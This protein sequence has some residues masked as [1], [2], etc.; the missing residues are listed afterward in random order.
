[1]ANEELGKHYEAIGEL[2]LALEAYTRMQPDLSTNK[3]YLECSRLRSKIYTQQRDW[4]AVGSTMKS[5]K[6]LLDEE[7]EDDRGYQAYYE[8]SMGLS[9][10]G[11][12]QYEEAVEHFLKVNP[13][14]S[15]DKY[16]DLVSPNDIATYG[17]LLALATKGRED[18]RDLLE[19]STYRSFSVT[20]PHLRK[21]I[22]HFVNA[23][24][25]ACL[26]VLESYRPD[27]LLD[28]YLQRHV[29]KLYTKIRQ[30]CIVQYLKPFSR[31]T[32]ESMEVFAA[33]GKCIEEDLV[34]M[35][36]AGTLEARIDKIDKV[37]TTTS[38]SPR[39]KIQK[40]SIN[41]L[42]SY[43][44]DALDQARRMGILAADLEVK[45]QRKQLIPGA[46]HTGDVMY[47]DGGMLS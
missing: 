19:Q 5:Q 15:A 28:V 18:L 31:V 46:P 9:L 45:G 22:T 35:I 39:F 42:T 12:E 24:Y 33:P 30:E 17:G 40:D 20:E 4:P 16:S 2:R 29:A 8:I 32:L 7:V 47:D 38:V 21:A 41:M 44:K 36:R 37:V 10:L 23:K 27:Y 26:D 14:I 13:G 6:D 25:S 34:D 11:T 1:M 43:K 3:Q